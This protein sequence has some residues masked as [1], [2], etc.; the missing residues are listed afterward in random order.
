MVSVCADECMC[1]YA[2]EHF[3]LYFYNI[4]FDKEFM[5]LILRTNNEHSIA[6]IIALAEKLNITIEQRDKKTDYNNN[7]KD[8]LKKRIL[9]FKAQDS[10]SFGDASEWQRNERNDHSFRNGRLIR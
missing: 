1:K 5:E 3:V 4:K 8:E 6:K 10:S 2:D 7:E 9:S